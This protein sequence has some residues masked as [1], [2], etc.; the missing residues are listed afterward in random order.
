MTPQHHRTTRFWCL[1]KREVALRLALSAPSVLRALTVT[2]TTNAL[3]S[4]ARAS[5]NW[6]TC[7]EEGRKSEG[8][9]PLS[10]FFNCTKLLKDGRFQLGYNTFTALY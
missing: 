6:P 4:G 2:R 9:W 3:A 5:R 1:M 8:I 7:T 10:V